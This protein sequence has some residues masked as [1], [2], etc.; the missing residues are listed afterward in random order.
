MLLLDFCKAFDKFPHCHFFSILQFYGVQG[1]LLRWIKNFLTNRSHQVIIDNKRSD[2]CNVLSG[3][4]Q[5]TVLAPLRFLICIN[6]LPLHVSNKVRLHANDVILYPY[7]YSMDDCCKLQKDLNSLTHWSHKWQM[8]FNARKC[9]FLRL[10][11]LETIHVWLHHK[12]QNAGFS[13]STTNRLHKGVSIYKAFVNLSS[14]AT[15]VFN[16]GLNVS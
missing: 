1:S 8:H 7:I 5:G 2:S 14:P 11:W 12:N 16:C 10:R 13:K 15:K 4:P 9:E 6:D 3:V